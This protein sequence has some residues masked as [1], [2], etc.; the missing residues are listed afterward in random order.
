MRVG[1]VLP[2]GGMS[3]ADG[4]ALAQRAEQAGVSGVYVVEA[5]RSAFVAL[6]A[7]AVATERVTI[8]P[9]V[10]NAYGRTP[11]IAGLSA[12]DLDDLSGGRAA[13]GVGSGN[14]FTNRVYQGVE[15]A[16][17][18]TKM[19]EYV[20]ILRRIVRARPGEPIEFRGDIHS[21][22]NWVPQNE[23]VR[24]AIPIY[25]AAIFPRMRR[26]AGRVADGI[27][28]G[29]L[30]SPEFIK[31]TVLPGIH[32]GAVAADRDPAKLGVK[33]AIFGSVSDD[34]DEAYDAA[35]TTIV[36]LFVP[37]PHKHYEQTLEEQ[38][39]G[40]V[41]KEVL[42]RLGDDDHAGAV[43]AVPDEVV[44]QLTISG[45]PAECQARIAAYRGLVDEVLLVNVGATR[46][47]LDAATAADRD[48][49]RS[50]FD[51][52]INVAGRASTAASS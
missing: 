44:E 33:M 26:V 8:G 3:I 36:N 35:R 47:R 24:A 2:G 42:T 13:I 30:L 16:R 6:A 23:P 37:K 51:P 46:H 20:E 25:L 4:V 1:V 22:S 49:I 5:W 39:Y 11:W 38:G 31:G 43:K 12:L 17:P 15:T 10:L 32:K 29:A 41:L 40:T 45:T 21:I 50:S 7:I 9:Y 48:T 14:V 19:A 34:R 18:L 28:L 27:A 52:V